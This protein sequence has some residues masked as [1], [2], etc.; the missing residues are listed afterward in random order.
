V[1]APLQ[2]SSVGWNLCVGTA[3]SDGERAQSA[4]AILELELSS[5]TPQGRGEEGT[6]EAS[7]TTSKAG[8]PVHL[9]MG[10]EEMAS[11]LT[12]LDTIQG[13]MDRLS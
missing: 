9:R 13:Q 7:E 10:R 6:E 3:A 11:L 4:H 1:L 12:K 5:S 8:R 2:L